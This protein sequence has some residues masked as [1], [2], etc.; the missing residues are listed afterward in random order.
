MSFWSPLG[1][2]GAGFAGSPEHAHRGRRIEDVASLLAHQ[3]IAKADFAQRGDGD[4]D[5]RVRRAAWNPLPGPP[6]REEGVDRERPLR[7]HALVRSKSLED[8][9]EVRSTGEI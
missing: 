2:L 3:P 8:A 9:R 7:A 5:P 1:G 4:V 6:G